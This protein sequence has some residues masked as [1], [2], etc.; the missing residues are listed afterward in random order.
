MLSFT[1][2][3]SF[4]I[5]AENGSFLLCTKRDPK[6]LFWNNILCIKYGLLHEADDLDAESMS[7]ATLQLTSGRYTKE[8]K[9]KFM[10]KDVMFR[11]DVKRYIGSS[12]VTIRT[13]T[14][15]LERIR[16][17]REIFG[18]EIPDEAQ[19]HIIGRNAALN[20]VH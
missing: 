5:D 10:Y 19:G 16:A 1:E 9:E 18:L 6:E 12:P 4:P 14:T 11:N 13:F 20:F 8:E 15:E 7:Q 17:L 3:E 2:N